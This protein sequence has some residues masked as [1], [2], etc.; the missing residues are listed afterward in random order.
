VVLAQASRVIANVSLARW[1]WAQSKVRITQRSHSRRQ[2]DDA[3]VASSFRNVASVASIALAILT[4]FDPAGVIPP[5]SRRQGLC[6][7][8]RPR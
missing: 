5:S 2:V 3:I 7:T 6:A 1:S 4:C 8:D